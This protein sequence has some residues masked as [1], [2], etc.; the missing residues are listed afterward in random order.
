MRCFACSNLHLLL[1]GVKKN[2]RVGIFLF[3]PRCIDLPVCFQ[4]KA[5]RLSKGSV[6]WMGKVKAFFSSPQFL[7]YKP[8]LS[9]HSTVLH[10][11]SES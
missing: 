2:G 5:V 4:Q 9:F 10:G 1:R 11:G 7:L 3:S 6:A 8:V